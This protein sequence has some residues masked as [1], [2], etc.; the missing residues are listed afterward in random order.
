MEGVVAKDTVE[1]GVEFGPYTGTLLDEEQ[2]WS[3]DTSWEVGS[4]S[5][6][7]SINRMFL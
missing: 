1:K 3:K 5:N 4:N 6:N 2:G 7:N